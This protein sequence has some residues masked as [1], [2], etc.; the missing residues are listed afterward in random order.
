MPGAKRRGRLHQASDLL[1]LDENHPKLHV[2]SGTYRG[3]YA[4]ILRKEYYQRIR[5]TAYK[6]F[7]KPSLKTSN[8]RGFLDAS[9]ARIVSYS[10]IKRHYA[11]LNGWSLELYRRKKRCLE[12]MVKPDLHNKSNPKDLTPETAVHDP[13][14]YLFKV[15][16]YLTSQVCNLCQ[17]RAMEDKESATGTDIHAVLQCT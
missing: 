6:R 8:M 7:V 16:E 1:T 5:K 13:N 9:N 10:S 15:N 17:T 2:P 11:Y 12:E 3:A 14:I 4:S